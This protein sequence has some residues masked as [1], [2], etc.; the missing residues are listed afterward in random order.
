MDK[1][2]RTKLRQLME[3]F[4][5]QSSLKY[6]IDEEGDFRVFFK[7]EEIPAYV[8]VVLMAAGT[9][10]EILSI[11]S[12]FET[13]HFLLAEED[14]LVLANNWNIENRWPRIYWLDGNF[15]GDF[16]LDVECGLPSAFVHHTLRR[17]LSAILQFLLYIG[18][19]AGD[20]G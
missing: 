11:V 7:V 3:R 1:E 15:Y 9:H 18:N 13:P 8:Q 14:A 6:T 19:Q 10:G 5:Q 20:K 4:L 2:I 17:L 16:H 12:R